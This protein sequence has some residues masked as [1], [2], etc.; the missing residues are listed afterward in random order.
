MTRDYKNTSASREK[1]AS[2]GNPF[3]TGLLIG[4]LLGVGASVA[5]VIF[6]NGGSNPF[7]NKVEPGAKI[8][9][10]GNS[11]A[12]IETDNSALPS[13]KSPDSEVTDDGKS[14]FDFYTI[15]PENESKVTEQEVKLKEAES[16]AKVVNE[17]YFLQVGAFQNETDADNQKAK[18]ALLGLEAIV[19]TAEIP[20]KGIWH[21]VRVGP[22]AELDQINKARKE[23]EANGFKVDL[24]KVNVKQEK[25]SQ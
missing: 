14:R 6:I 24:I 12:P 22:Y 18:L 2:K 1:P 21:R 9:S 16:A 4:L 17:S 5:L 8:E 19:Q 20:E 11:D 13:G 15:L 10:K 3:L 23:L 25:A 7:V